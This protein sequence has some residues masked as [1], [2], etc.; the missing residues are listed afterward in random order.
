MFQGNHGRTSQLRLMVNVEILYTYTIEGRRHASNGPAVSRA[1]CGETA[2][3]R[4]CGVWRIFRFPEPQKSR[5]RQRRRLSEDHHFPLVGG[6]MVGIGANQD[7][8]MS[9]SVLGEKKPL[10]P[11][12]TGRLCDGPGRLVGWSS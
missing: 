12:G 4:P 6:A 9:W 7:K 10:V 8:D 1:R 3:V 2:A 5:K 11:S